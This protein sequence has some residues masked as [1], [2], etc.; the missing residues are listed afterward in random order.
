[1]AH[2]K[3]TLT[4]KLSLLILVAAIVSGVVFLTLQKITDHLIEGYLSSDEY[5]K[6]ESARYIQTFSRYVSEH[7]LTST[8]RKAFGEWVKKKIILISLFTRMKCFNMTRFTLP[9]TNRPMGK[10]R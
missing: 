8:D 7:E 5:Y 9:L 10:K 4:K 6:E 3:Y 1:M 2:R